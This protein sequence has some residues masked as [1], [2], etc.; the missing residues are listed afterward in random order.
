MIAPQ[1]PTASATNY[2]VGNC[3]A[4]SEGQAHIREHVAKLIGYRTQ[5]QQVWSSISIAGH[6]HV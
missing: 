4:S 1:P 6:V 3:V 2:S 5:D